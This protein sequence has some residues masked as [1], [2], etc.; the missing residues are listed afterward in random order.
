[1]A[2]IDHE[3]STKSQDGDAA[4][5]GLAESIQPSQDL[6]ASLDSEDSVGKTRSKLQVC[7]ILSALYVRTP[8]MLWCNFFYFFLAYG[9]LTFL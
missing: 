4:Q 9:A 1:M 2:N 5:L 6:S 8:A 3:A 7:C